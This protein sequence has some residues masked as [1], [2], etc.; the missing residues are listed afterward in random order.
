[1]FSPA[2]TLTVVFATQ[3]HTYPA[4]TVH[5]YASVSFTPVVKT[6]AGNMLIK[7]SV[8]EEVI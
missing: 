1:M 5:R 2:Y 3:C 4:A 6:E 7:Y 8:W